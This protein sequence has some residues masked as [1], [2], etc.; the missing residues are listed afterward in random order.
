MSELTYI[1]GKDACL[2]ASITNMQTILQ[3]AGFDIVEASWL[4]PVANVY[5]LHIH[6]ARCPG[7]FTNGNGTSRKAT[8]SSSLG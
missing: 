3:A 4:N 1:K 5:S 8:L 2:E 7:L 6:D